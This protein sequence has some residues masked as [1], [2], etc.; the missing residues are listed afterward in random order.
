MKKNV[1]ADL[2]LLLITIIWGATFVVVQNAISTL[3]PL[4]FNGIRFFLASAF[5]FLFLIMFYR[6]Q[7]RIIGKKLLAAGIILGFWL[8]CGYAFQTVG[9]LYTTTS[10]AGFITGLSVVLVPLFAFILLKQRPK[11]AAVAGILIATV[12]LYLLTLSDSL[13]INKGDFLVFL[14]AIS[15]ALQIILTGRYAPRFPSLVLSLV[16]ILT[17]SVLSS[18]GALFFENWQVALKPAAMM[19]PAVYWALLITA[20]PAT[21]L[22]F[23]AQTECQKFTTPTRVA[24]IFAMEPVF[25]AIT[26]YFFTSDVLTGRS[27]AGCLCI[28]I[29]MIL[30]ELPLDQIIARVKEKVSAPIGKN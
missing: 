6:D 23:L 13:T 16:Q 30:A 17:V 20:I 22:A 26:A 4:T 27:L 9:L 12:G 19:T 7:I 24:L 21:A 29:G 25:A 1:V 28:F 8:F 18:I 15:F 10:K 2:I 3:P 14:C 11:V 5:L